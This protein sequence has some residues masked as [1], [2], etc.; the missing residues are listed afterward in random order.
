MPGGGV[1]AR[2]IENRKK[3]KGLVVGAPQGNRPEKTAGTKEKGNQGE[4]LLP[5]PPQSFVR[6]RGF[7]AM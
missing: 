4:T 3:E 5:G 2:G 7:S 1:E 6:I